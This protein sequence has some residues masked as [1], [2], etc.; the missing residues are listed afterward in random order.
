MM[1][2]MKQP[3]V[4]IIIPVYNAKAHLEACVQ[5]ILDQ[6][7]Q[8]FEL[9]LIDDG[10]SDGSSGLCDELSQKSEKIRVIYKENGGVSTARNRGLEE[11]RGEFII[12]VD[13]DDVISQNYVESFIE[14]YPKRTKSKINLIIVMRL[15]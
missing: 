10:S 13:C 3:L 4:S 11:A 6:S 12:F 9:L 1:N 5:S 8:Q 2:T 14:L 15:E 7:Y